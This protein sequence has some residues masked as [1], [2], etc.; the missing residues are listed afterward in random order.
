[1]AKPNTLTFKK[2]PINER[3]YNITRHGGNIWVESELNKGST[4]YLCLHFDNEITLQVLGRKNPI[5]NF[6]VLLPFRL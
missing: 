1:M 2:H 3:H 5:P 6:K 4:F